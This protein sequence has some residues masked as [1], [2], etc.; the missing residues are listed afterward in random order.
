MSHVDFIVDCK[1]NLDTAF[2]SP[3]SMLRENQSFYATDFRGHFDEMVYSACAYNTVLF[4][5]WRVQVSSIRYSRSLALVRSLSGS[6][7]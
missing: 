2:I 6:S 4:Q 1:F 7:F 5:L 3:Q